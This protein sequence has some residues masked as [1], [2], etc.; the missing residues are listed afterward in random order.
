MEKLQKDISHREK[1]VSVSARVI[2]ARKFKGYSVDTEPRSWTVVEPLLKL[3]L[4]KQVDADYISPK[5][6]LIIK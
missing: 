3:R 1:R 5:M 2:E 4:K 6:P